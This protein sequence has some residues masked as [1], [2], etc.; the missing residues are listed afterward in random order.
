[1]VGWLVEREVLECVEKEQGSRS[2]RSKGE[3][4]KEEIERRACS[5]LRIVVVVMSMVYLYKVFYLTRE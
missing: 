1:M 5:C 4:A 2:R 3:D